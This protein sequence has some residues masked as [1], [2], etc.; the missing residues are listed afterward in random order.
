M[1]EEILRTSEA[2]S[3]KLSLI[4]RFKYNEKIRLKV[5]KKVVFYWNFMHHGDQQDDV[6][7]R[8][9]GDYFINY[10]IN[11]NYVVESTS[12]KSGAYLPTLE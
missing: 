11:D 3:K 1:F 10:K 7:Q 8:I 9:I 2:L 5:L 6:I 12:R 4:V